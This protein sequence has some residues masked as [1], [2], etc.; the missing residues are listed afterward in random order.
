MRKAVIGLGFGDEGKGTTVEYLTRTNEAKINVRF[1][2]GPQA[3]HNVVLK[4]GTH[5]T[6]A[7][8]GSGTFA[9]AKTLITRFFSVDL[10]ALRH[11]AMAIFEVTRTDPYANLLVSENAPIIT[12]IH[13]ALNIW[14]EE[15]RGNSIHGSTGRGHGESVLESLNMPGNVLY[16]GELLDASQI[17][18]KLEFQAARAKAVTQGD[19]TFTK[20]WLSETVKSL[21]YAVR[22]R[23][24]ALV[25]DENV[26]PYGDLTYSIVTDD[27]ISQ[28]IR[29]DEN[30]IFEGSQGVLLDEWYGFHPHTTWSTVT[31]ANVTELLVEAGLPEDDYRTVGVTRTYLTRHGA[32]PFLTEVFDESFAKA[33]PEP[34]NSDLG[35]AGVW[36]RGALD[37]NM[38]EYAASAATE[39]GRLDEVAV[40]HLD[41]PLAP[42]GVIDETGWI[43]E[44]L[45]QVAD[46]RFEKFEQGKAVENLILSSRALNAS[47]DREVF[48]K[49][50]NEHE[51]LSLITDTIHKPVTIKSYGPTFEDK[52]SESND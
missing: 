37:L 2:G 10:W 52:V 35:F 23:P 7:Q 33:Y 11:E 1:C 9:G 40:T 38:L 26:I 4:D 43:R 13:V 32:G 29:A 27:Q 42:V 19:L 3:A 5:H 48:K 39:N 45:D 12:P 25:R 16:A 21:T 15:Q 14:R 17:Y 22:G 34:H 24:D 36:R 8:F 41:R 47:A 51:L 30:A 6:F 18:K 28:E 44:E 46:L 50:E 49:L 20:E 31:S